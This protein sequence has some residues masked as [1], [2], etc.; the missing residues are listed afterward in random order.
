ME[1]FFVSKEGSIKCG[2]C[3][4]TITHYLGNGGSDGP[5]RDLYA[6]FKPWPKQY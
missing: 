2:K 1:S 4:E 5:E 6:T 3:V